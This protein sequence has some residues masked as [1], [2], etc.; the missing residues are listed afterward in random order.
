VW[1]DRS[2]RPDQDDREPLVG[3]GLRVVFGG[4]AA[5]D[6]VDLRL[7]RREILGLIGPNGAGKTTLVNAITRFLPLTDGTVTCGAAHISALPAR[8]VAH[9]G[10]A[11][12]FQDGRLFSSLTVAENVEVGGLGVGRSRREVRRIAAELLAWADLAG[13]GD[14]LASALPYGARRIVGVLRALVS[15]PRFLFLDEPAAG[16][17]ESETDALLE[18]LREIPG[19]FDCGMLIIEHDMSLIMRLC[20]RIQV[21]DHGQTLAI[22]SPD[23]IRTNRKVI[24]AYLG[25]RE[26]ELR[27]ELLE[28]QEG[29]DGA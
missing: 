12:T 27:H 5:V 1:T 23:E 10:L 26:T 2:K 15:A 16:I 25:T 17:A 19:R 4:V 29:G 21:L 28:H 18:L 13:Q 20:E 7:D 8:R 14:R 11:R 3:S 24:E 22:G 6:G 9:A